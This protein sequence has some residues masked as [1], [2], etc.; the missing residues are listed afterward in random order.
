MNT[1][2]KKLIGSAVLLVF[3]AGYIWAATAIAEMI[4]DQTPLKA[5]FYV[6]AGLCW[7]VPILP[8]IS[9]MNRSK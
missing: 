6:V 9:W 4:P 5:L 7:G 8:L 2:A 3:L 1:R